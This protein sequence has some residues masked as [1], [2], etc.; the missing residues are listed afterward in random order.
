MKEA[1]RKTAIILFFLR[2]SRLLV[3]VGTLSASAQFFGVGLE[4]ESWILCLNFVV[5]L[6]LALWGPLNE[7]FRAK[8]IFLK[9]EEGAS[10]ALQRAGSLI[11]VSLSAM[12]CVVLIMELFSLPVARLIAPAFTDTALSR[13]S[14]L[15]RYLLWSA[16]LSQA[17]QLLSSILNTYDSFY[18]PEISGFISA[19]INLALIILLGDSI[20]I[21]SFLIANYVSA[22]LLLAALVYQINKLKI[23]LFRQKVSFSWEQVKPFIL[24][25]IPFFFP[26]LFGQCSSFIEKLIANLLQHNTVAIIDYSRRIPDIIQAVLTSVL[27]T[28][29]V[30]VLSSKFSEGKPESVAA[31]SKKYIQMMFLMLALIIPALILCSDDITTILYDK[32]TIGVRDLAM[33]SLLIKLYAVSLLGIFSYLVFGLILLSV[34][35][36]RQYALYGVVAQLLMILINVCLYRFCG[37]YTFAIALA[38]SHMISAFFLFHHL[39]FPKKEILLTIA[40]YGCVLLFVALG[41]YLVNSVYSPA[42]A[43]LRIVYNGL[44]LSALF[45]AAALFLKLPEVSLIK[46]SFVKNKS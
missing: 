22:L 31:E 1:S 14:V 24:Y 8:F 4:R 19:L 3:S 6:Q 33:I 20:G 9:A 23:P 28:I 2:F 46:S 36:N 10:V 43:F 29:M 45:V 34:N 12:A 26:Y 11:L 30:P 44:L 17:T 37:I 42:Y 5:I 39:P 16:I 15:L 41:G 32:G 38:A 21:Y 35:K 40:R 7:T 13:L 27:A 25:S 18:I